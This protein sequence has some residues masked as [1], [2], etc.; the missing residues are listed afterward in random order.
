MKFKISLIDKSILINNLKRF[1]WIGVIYFIGLL[2][3]PLYI[4]TQKTRVEND[5][6]KAIP[7]IFNTIWSVQGLFI[8]IISIFLGTLLFRYIQTKEACDSIHSLPITRAVLF[9]THILSGF[10]ILFIPML[11]SMLI[12]II[13]KAFIGVPVLFSVADIVKWSLI[14]ILFSIVFFI[15]TVFSGM[16]TGNSL[17]Q[18]L[19]ATILLL[20][21][22]F[23]FVTITYNFE[24]LIFGYISSLSDI[25]WTI[26]SPI[27][28]VLGL[29]TNKLS[30]I[31]I[32][33]YVLLIIILTIFSEFLYK[34]RKLEMAGQSIAFTKLNY[35][36]KY[37]AAFC[38]MLLF[39]S[40]FKASFNSVFSAY[41]G[42]VIGSFLCYFIAEMIINKTFWV[43]RNYKGYLIFCLVFVF[44]ITGIKTDITGF[45][46]YVPKAENIKG[47]YFSGY[48][49]YNYSIYRNKLILNNKDY[50]DNVLD[51]HKA[52]I[53]SKDKVL[54]KQN[55]KNNQ[56]RLDATIV[57]ILKNNKEIVRK[58][59]IVRNDFF[60]Y[61]KPIYENK[62][63]KEKKEKIF[64]V[65]YPNIKSIWIEREKSN[66]GTFI[67]QQDIKELI[68]LIK[69]EIYNE[70]YEDM[71]NDKA[72]WGH[73]IIKLNNPI[74]DYKIK[75][76][77]IFILF[78]KN[79]LSLENWFENKGYLK[80][81]RI[82]PDEIKYVA[83]GEIDN[84]T[85]EYI[86]NG[87]NEQL[88]KNSFAKIYDKK[89]IEYYLREYKSIWNYLDKK[90]Y[91]LLFIDKMNS[92][93]DTGYIDKIR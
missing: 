59:N 23:L 32:I 45:E 27:I 63:Y 4:I 36:F 52:I 50:I 31:E 80:N 48:G 65:S 33:I 74:K 79:Y 73:I 39:G 67:K 72:P 70:K 47:V 13:I 26:L 19:V 53:K 44:I 77:E 88:L 83:I 71:I 25:N 9:R 93:Y 86:R 82:L 69:K 68:D 24:F 21:P 56:A 18:A 38:G 58:Y 64:E 16:L 62:E 11:I 5:Y 61:L 12:I 17:L 46:R 57:Y 30:T 55:N 91:Y 78:K 42:Y 28:R 6:I 85:S 84:N 76:D 3:I 14:S 75:T 54:N 2:Y 43:F 15:I 35:L 20:L 81:I 7:N 29:E 40:Y 34:I 87:S 22:A 66:M 8:L 89:L 51:L 41:T 37:T 90:G 1:G 92:S 60:G 10:I 49:L